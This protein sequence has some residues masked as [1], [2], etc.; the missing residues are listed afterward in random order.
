MPGQSEDTWEG[1][2]SAIGVHNVKFTKKFN[3]MLTKI[4]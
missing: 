3:K 1:E 2:M 4:W